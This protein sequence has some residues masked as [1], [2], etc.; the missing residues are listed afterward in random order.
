M[1]AN[2]A[3][4]SRPAKLRV[5]GVSFLNSKPLIWGLDQ[6]SEIELR[7]DVP[8]HLIEYLRSGACDMA[9]LPVIDYQ[10]LPGLVVVP[11]GGIGCEGP[12]LTVRIF[13][14]RPIEEIQ[15]MRCD[16]DSHTSVALARIILAELYD[17][18]PEF[19]DLNAGTPAD[20]QAVLLIGDKVICE[21]PQGYEH[22]LDLGEAWHRLTGLPFVFAVWTARDSIDLG[23]LPAQLIHARRSGMQHIEQI[24]NRFAVPRGWPVEIAR[25]YLTETLKFEIG[26]RQLQAIAQFHQL[27]HKHGVLGGPIVPLRVYSEST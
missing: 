11:S 6:M 21:E 5:G 22:Q 18:R 12:T 16:T 8:S 27:A 20:S 2:I 3:A 13:S 4:K 7:L 17:I 25:T 1:N 26:P 23:E 9:L 19:V 10:R 15:L 14:R 24:I